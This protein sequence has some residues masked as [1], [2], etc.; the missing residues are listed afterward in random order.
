M[1]QATNLTINDGQTTPVART[2]TLITPGADG[3]FARWR[4]KL[5]GFA[6]SDPTMR[7][8]ARVSEGP[9]PA[10]KAD[11]QWKIPYS[12]LNATTGIRD[13]HST[14]EFNGSLTMPDNFPENMR[15]DAIAYIRNGMDALVAGLL[16]AES[17]T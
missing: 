8:R 1:P 10:R 3:E 12:T 6:Y 11:V 17:Y 7:F 16:D 9:K 15:P 2:F 5:T 14:V 4:A 13:V